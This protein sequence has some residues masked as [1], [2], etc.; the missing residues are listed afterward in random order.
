MA[1]HDVR[2]RDT[3]LEVA[4]EGG[5]LRGDHDPNTP[6]GANDES[7]IADT[8][9][10]RIPQGS[11]FMELYCN[12]QPAVYS[13][14]ANLA[15]RGA[16]RASIQTAPR[17]LYNLVDLNAD[18]EFDVAR[19]DLTRVAP[20][21]QG[22]TVGAPV[23]RIAISDP[24]YTNSPL[25]EANPNR[26]RASHPNSYS[27]DPANPFD[28]EP[29]TPVTPANTLTL[30]RIVLF[31]NYANVTQLNAVASAMSDPV[32]P[33]TSDDIFF[34]PTG[35]NPT[36]AR[37]DAGGYMVLAP[38]TVTRLGSQR[39]VEDTGGGNT[40][41]AQWP[42]TDPTSVALP[43]DP[44]PQRFAIDAAE[45]MRRF[46]ITNANANP[47]I[48][49]FDPP[50]VFKVKTF[51]PAGWAATAFD[52]QLVGLSVSEPKPRGGS[53]YF[54]PTQRLDSNNGNFALTDAYV[55]YANTTG[56]GS[57]TARDRPEDLR[58]AGSP[59]DLLTTVRR[60]ANA[61]E[62]FLGTQEE[63]CSAF[64]QRLADPLRPHDSV[65]NP[66]ITVDWMTID[67]T[68]FSGEE[69][70]EALSGAAIA[71]DGYAIRS[72]QRDGEDASNPALPSN[73]L[74]SYST[75]DGTVTP[76][77]VPADA[78]NYFQFTAAA[79]ANFEATLGMLNFNAGYFGP[80]LGASAT[81]N[82]RQGRGQPQ[83]PFATHDW[84]NRP[85]ASHYELM[86]VPATSPSRLFEEFTVGT[87][88]STFYPP[89]GTLV[90][91]SNAEE[92]HGQHRHLLNFFQSSQVEDN[93]AQFTRLL[94]Y[95]TTLPRFRGEVDLTQC[96]DEPAHGT[97]LLHPRQ[98][99]SGT[100]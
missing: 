60:G 13:D 84:L 51:R 79:G 44:S 65:L 38:R 12:R 16:D 2:V 28:V 49:T 30:D 43:V 32:D 11:L 77:A 72:R 90:D 68:V 54:E 92:F 64:L 74:F 85:F 41:P 99:A 50:Q 93:T 27:F 55:D 26:L 100:D 9:S 76:G 5:S 20:V 42:D 48:N 1:F 56:P 63:Y 34:V 87:A 94:D 88:T 25:E 97:V 6:P 35:I 37:I 80:T 89:A 33:I 69:S 98:R 95:V 15:V 96:F 86:M 66:Y 59:I 73:S 19:L 75:K 31:R 7:G 45:G 67:L 91:D 14:P 58:V 52:D 46:D 62:P 40:A 23:W 22:Q 36:E 61:E 17:E 18:G 83:V 10:V 47:N 70:P 39:Y 78:A 82:V 21:A 3:V 53:Y 71:A 81:M 8:D 57:T 29:Q 24:H 4:N